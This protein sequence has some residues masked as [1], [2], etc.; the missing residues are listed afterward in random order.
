MRIF[1]QL[2]LWLL[3]W[4]LKNILLVLK[5]NL[6]EL[7]IE[8]WEKENLQ[9][10]SACKNH[11]GSGQIGQMVLKLAPTKNRM[12]RLSTVIDVKPM[13]KLQLAKYQHGN[14]ARDWFEF[15]WTCY[16]L[17]CFTLRAVNMIRFTWTGQPVPC[18][19]HLNKSVNCYVG[20]TLWVKWTEW[21]SLGGGTTKRMYN[22]L[23]AQRKS[24][25]IWIQ[26]DII[27]VI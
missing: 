16:L 19:R 14:D 2:D 24:R 8:E 13:K 1:F 12:K 23:M 7:S 11:L 21:I 4:H 27:N 26:H 17:F 25:K 15:E 9:K 22:E 10:Y 18:K 20:P 5:L 6:W 3:L